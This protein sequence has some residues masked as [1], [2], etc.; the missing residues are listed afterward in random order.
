MPEPL[1]RPDQFTVKVDGSVANRGPT[2]LVGIV[3][4]MVLVTLAVSRGALV[5]KTTPACCTIV[6]P[7]VKPALGCTVYWTKPS[8]STRLWLSGYKNPS[9]TPVGSWPVTGS[10]EVKVTF[11][12]P[13]WTLKFMATATF[14]DEPS[15]FW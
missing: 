2:L 10:R 7:V 5:S 8:L 4:S 13:V 6:F 12:R 9:K 15:E 14:K 3:L 1:S 11:K